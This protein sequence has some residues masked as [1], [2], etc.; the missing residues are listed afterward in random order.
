MK[1]ALGW[2]L[3]MRPTNTKPQT[4][5]FCICNSARVFDGL[6]YCL[7]LRAP[8]NIKFRLSREIKLTSCYVHSSGCYLN[9]GHSCFEGPPKR[10]STSSS[11]IR[12]LHSNSLT[13]K[14]SSLTR[15]EAQDE[16]RARVA[17]S[18]ARGAK[19]IAAH[20]LLCT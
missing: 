15:F 7:N 12:Y 4:S 10:I 2:F 8:K 17:R 13:S 5:L 1:S 18:E 9:S 14:S 6:L 11:Y 16:A 19:C 20:G 3:W